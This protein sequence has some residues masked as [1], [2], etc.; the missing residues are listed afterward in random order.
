MGSPGSPGYSM[1]ICTFYEKQFRDSLSDYKS[2]FGTVRYFDDLRAIVVSKNSDQSSRSL[3]KALIKTIANN[4][5]H[6]SMILI[7][8]ENITNS[9]RFLESQV[10]LTSR[11]RTAFMASKNYETLINTGKFTVTNAQSFHSFAGEEM[12]KYQTRMGT[13]LGRLAAAESYSHPKEQLFM[14]FIHIY[15][16]LRALEYPPT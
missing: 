8:E 1:A 6:E 16:Q 14:S 2:L 10:K 4:C 3:A 12:G 11:T 15:T 13:V 9:F 5:Y 7:P